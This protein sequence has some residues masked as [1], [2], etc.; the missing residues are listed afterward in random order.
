MFAVEKNV[1]AVVTLQHLKL[2]QWG[3][4]VESNSVGRPDKKAVVRSL[5]KNSGSNSREAIGLR[6]VMKD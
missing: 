2:E 4:Q 1:N 5:V 3:D 6:S